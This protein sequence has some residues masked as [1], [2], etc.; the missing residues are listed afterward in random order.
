MSFSGKERQMGEQ[1]R[2]HY[3]YKGIASSG[4]SESEDTVKR[5]AY[6]VFMQAMI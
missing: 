5:W 2:R 4:S 1:S 6:R 3:K